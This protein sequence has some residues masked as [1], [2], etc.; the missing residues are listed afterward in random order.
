MP[1]DTSKHV[2]LYN[3]N[4]QVE[5]QTI[6]Q[7]SE[8]W[9]RWVLHAPASTPVGTPF[10]AANGYPEASPDNALVNNNGDVF[11]LFGGDW[12]N[13]VINVPADKPIFLPMINA[14][15]IEGPNIETI[16]N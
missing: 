9:L 4:A 11:F 12:D 2:Q 6:Q 13:A 5:G 14:F 15:D 3:Q 1:Q 7:W 10:G 8:D 16:P